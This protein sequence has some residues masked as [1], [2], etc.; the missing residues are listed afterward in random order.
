MTIGRKGRVEMRLLCG[1]SA[2]GLA[3]VYG[4]INPIL[5]GRGGEIGNE[6][7]RGPAT[8]GVNPEAETGTVH[9]SEMRRGVS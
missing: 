4:R 6:I 3:H 8:A 5:T 7:A 1:C 9:P 2:V